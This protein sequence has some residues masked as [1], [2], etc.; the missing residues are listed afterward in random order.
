M[1]LRL[2][3]GKE[4]KS[5]SASYKSAQGAA[6][7]ELPAEFGALIEAHQLLRRHGQEICRR[8]APLCERC[9]VTKEC[10]YYRNARVRN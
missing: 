4:Q 8:S 2:G 9:P 10:A 7:A 6:A 1:L 5:Y 3:Y